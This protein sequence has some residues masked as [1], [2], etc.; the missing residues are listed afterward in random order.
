MIGSLKPKSEFSRNLLTLMTGTALAQA[1]PIAIMPILTRIYSPEQ[2]GVFAL[3]MAFT[4]MVAV[5]ATG[6]YELAIM[7]PRKNEDAINILVLSVLICVAVTLVTFVIVFIFN[8]EI[9]LL[10]GDPSISIWLYFVPISVFLTGIY[11]SLNYW[12]NRN[13]Q[14]KKIAINRVAQASTTGALNL[15]MGIGGIGIAGLVL[16]SLLGQVIATSLFIKVFFR[17]D[18]RYLQEIK[19]LKI[20]ALVK[21]YKKM[22]I[23]NLPN[24]A[25]DNIRLSGIFILIAK[26]YSTATL[27]Q[28]TLAWK[29]VQAPMAIVGSSISQVFFQKLSN[30]SK[31]D[32]YSIV[33]SFLWK[34]FL[35][36]SPI[37]LVIYFVAPNVFSF[38]FGSDWI[39]AGQAVSI[40]TPWL[41]FNFIS[42]PLSTL[43]I[44]LNKQEVVLLFSIAYMTVPLALLV[45]FNKLEFLVILE[46]IT[47]SMSIMLV[48]FIGLIVFYTKKESEICMS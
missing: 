12:N 22:P 38:F 34:A 14:Y 40:M 3:Y 10:L 7:L 46:L 4:T 48:F 13:K 5:L 8:A 24:V 42:S 36:S 27:G 44:I 21:K 47:L 2:F 39:L 26:F 41:F 30:S 31:K 1:I 19:G 43:Y 16:G 37:F 23:Y 11:Q 18:H 25:V 15:G 17:K 9:T 45:I 6:R 20:L 35:F 32:L 29:A 33:L 28:F